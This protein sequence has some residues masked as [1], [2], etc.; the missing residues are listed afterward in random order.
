M[1]RVVGRSQPSLC[2]DILPPGWEQGLTASASLDL[3]VAASRC[4]SRYAAR[5]QSQTDSG[6]SRKHAT[7]IRAEE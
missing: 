3:P 7:A 5:P 1:G 4:T 2:E 6:H